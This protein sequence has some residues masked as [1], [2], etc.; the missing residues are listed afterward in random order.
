MYL[1]SSKAFFAILFASLAILR[2]VYASWTN[3]IY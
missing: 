3:K 1:D 2:L